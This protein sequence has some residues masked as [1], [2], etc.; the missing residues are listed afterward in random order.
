MQK[1]KILTREIVLDERYCPIEKQLVELPNGKT[2]DWFVNKTPDAVIVIPILKNG[3][4]VLQ[5]SYKHG[6]GEFIWEFPAGMMDQEHCETKCAERE[7]LEETGLK[8]ELEKTG[9]TFANATGAEM[10]YHFFVA[11]I[12]R[13][14]LSRI[15]NQQNRLSY[16][17]LQI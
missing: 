14:W 6:C 12:V 3:R 13:R 2:A 8:G 5:K 17:I 16:M 10:R 7:L 1:F 11:R 4:I 15:W 9:E